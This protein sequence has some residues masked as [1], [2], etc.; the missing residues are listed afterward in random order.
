MSIVEEVPILLLS[1]LVA[2]LLRLI[3]Y[4]CIILHEGIKT[5]L[6]FHNNFFLSLFPSP[7]RVHIT[8]TLEATTT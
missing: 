4:A 2:K 6:R 8:R 1:V 5:C 7:F 3:L